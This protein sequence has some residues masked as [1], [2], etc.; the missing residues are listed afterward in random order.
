[1]NISSKNLT[2]SNLPTFLEAL[3]G[4][5][6]RF[7]KELNL[8]IRSTWSLYANLD[9]NTGEITDLTGLDINSRDFY[10]LDIKQNKWT[11]KADSQESPA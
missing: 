11:V 1:V 4:E 10:V 6:V 8:P 7:I 3:S 5:V 2:A 9:S